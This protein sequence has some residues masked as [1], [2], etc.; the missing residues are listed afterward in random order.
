MK[1]TALQKQRRLDKAR[2]K[3]QEKRLLQSEQGKDDIL[4]KRKKLS[5]NET[6][7]QRNSYHLI[8]IEVAYSLCD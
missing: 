5:L 1:E 8:Q 3:R 7:D 6:E 4:T 2:V